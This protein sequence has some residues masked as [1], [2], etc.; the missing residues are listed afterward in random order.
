[1]KQ[2]I[3]F[4]SYGEKEQNEIRNLLKCNQYKLGHTSKNIQSLMSN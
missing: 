3:Y 4:D 1:M 2:A